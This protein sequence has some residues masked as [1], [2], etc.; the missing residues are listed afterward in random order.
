MYNLC[1]LFSRSHYLAT[2]YFFLLELVEF[3]IPSSSSTF[4]FRPD[5]L[6]SSRIYYTTTM[7]SQAQ[8]TLTMDVCEIQVSPSYD[9][10][11]TSW[12][13]F[14]LNFSGQAELSHTCTLLDADGS[15]LSA[16]S[17]ANKLNTHRQQSL[18]DVCG[19]DSHLF[20][21][22]QNDGGILLETEQ[23]GPSLF[24]SLLK[25]VSAATNSLALFV[26]QSQRVYSF[27]SMGLPQPQ[28]I[29]R[30]GNHKTILETVFPANTS[31]TAVAQLKA[32]SASFRFV[33]ELTTAAWQTTK[34]VQEISILSE[35]D[36]SQILKWNEVSYRAACEP[37]TET[38]LDKIRTMSGMAGQRL[39]L[40]SSTRQITYS[41]LDNLSNQLAGE[42][43]LFS[44][45]LG[46]FL[47]IICHKSGMAIVAMLAA[48]KSGAGFALIDP[49]LPEERLESLLSQLQSEVVLFV[50]E[51]SAHIANVATPQK[52][53]QLLVPPH[54]N[55]NTP[56]G[57]VLLPDCSLSDAAYIIFTSGTTGKPKGVVIEHH[58][59]S[60]SMASLAA[61][62]GL[63]ADTRMLQ[64]ASY[65]FDACIMET[66]STLI[67]GG[68]IF[69]P[70]DSERNNSL[71]EFI[72]QHSLNAMLLTPSVLQMLDPT[73]CPTINT[74]FT[75]GEKMSALATEKWS[76]HVRLINAYGPTETSVLCSLLDGVTKDTPPE[77]LGWAL[78]SS[79]WIVDAEDP[80]RLL[81]IGAVGELVVCGTTLA[82]G[83]LDDPKKT[84]AAFLEN[85]D[86]LPDL[87]SEQVL[88]QR[89]YRTGDL[90]RYG[91]DGSI[92][93]VGR[94]DQQVK[95]RGQRIE[96][97]EIELA[98]RK[99]LPPGRELAVEVAR[100]GGPSC[101]AQL[102]VF[103]VVNIENDFG[104]DVSPR[105][106]TSQT[107]LH[108]FGLLTN[109]L[110]QQLATVLPAY[111]VPSIYVPISALPLTRSAKLDRKLMQTWVE[112]MSVADL[113]KFSS[114]STTKGPAPE[115][116]TE[117]VLQGLWSQILGAS[118]DDISR[119]GHFF[120]LG[121]DS[122]KA[123]KLVSLG[124]SERLSMT[125]EGIF[126]YPVLSELAAHVDFLVG[127]IDHQSSNPLPFSL[128]ET[129]GDLS[130]DATFIEKWKSEAAIQ[131]AVATELVEDIY[132]CT[133]LQE[134]MLALSLKNPDAYTAHFTFETPEV[135]FEKLVRAWQ[136]VTRR[137]SILRTKFISDSSARF[138]QV[139]LEDDPQTVT[140]C[141]TP[142][143][144]AKNDFR[145]ALGE[146]A[147]QIRI[148]LLDGGRAAVTWSS[149]HATY[150]A[151]SVRQIL[152]DVESTY[153][154]ETPSPLRNFSS[155]IRDTRLLNNDTN[156]SQF[157]TSQLQ[158]A[159]TCA[160]PPQPVS[161][162][163]T[164]NATF[165]RRV[166]FSRS[167]SC[168]ITAANL[169][170]AAWA[171][172]LSQYSGLED[173]V[174]GV[175]TSGRTLPI[176]DIDLVRGP[177]IATVPVRTSVKRGTALADF[178][179]QVQKQAV[180]MIPFEQFGLQNIRELSPSARLA[181]DI[182]SLLI[183]QFPE[184]ARPT[185]GQVELL[186][187]TSSKMEDVLTYPLNIECTF[188]Q[189]SI[190][191]N[192]Q[193]DAVLISEVQVQRALAS[194]DAAL[195]SVTQ[196][197][198]SVLLGDLK[199]ISGMDLEQIHLWNSKMPIPTSV[200]I[201]EL[202][203][204][205]AR[206]QP[207][208]AA[209]SAHDGDLTYGQLM[210]HS[211]SLAGKLQKF[212]VGKGSIVPIC[213]EKSVWTQVAILAVLMSGATFVLLDPKLPYARLGSIIED[214]E[215]RIIICQP[216]TSH[217]VSES[218]AE[219]LILDASTFSPVEQGR[220]EN[221]TD[222]L[223]L[224]KSSDVSAEDSA[225]I[226]FTSG[227]TGKPKGIVVDHVALSSTAMA[228][229]K[230]IQIDS[231][232]RVLQFAAYTFDVSIG[233]MLVTL[234]L[235][236]C[237]CVPSESQRLNDLAG[238]MR[239]LKVNHACITSTVAMHLE[240][241][242]VPGLKRLVIGG[243]PMNQVLI[244][245]WATKVD[246]VNIYGP[247]ECT[248][249]CMGKLAL[250]PSDSA[251]NIGY[252]LG[253]VAWITEIDHPEKLAP[254]GAIGELILEGPTLA[255]GYFKDP[256][257][258]AGA[259]LNNPT[260]AV[261]QTKGNSSNSRRV[262]RTGDLV[263]YA[264]DGT[265]TFV[266]RRDRQ[267]KLRGQRIEL[268]EIEHHLRQ[269]LPDQKSE[270]I[271][272][273]I[274]LQGNASGP[275]L[276]AFIT[277][278]AS[279]VWETSGA[280]D[281]NSTAL[282]RF[283]KMLPEMEESMSAA[284]PSYMV[285]TVFIPMENFPLSASGKLDR[286][287]LK[288]WAEDIS[289][290]NISA[291]APK[292]RKYEAPEGQKETSLASLWSS[293]LEVD[294]QIGRHDHFFRMGGDSIRA[295]RL[296][297]AARRQG[298][299]LSVESIFKKP[300]LINMVTQMEVSEYGSEDYEENPVP[301]SLLD[302]DTVRWVKEVVAPGY[303]IQV[304]DIEDAS[305]CT[306]LQEGLVSMSLK[307]QGSY[308]A[309]V[310]YH[311][312][313]SVDLDRLEEVWR[314]MLQNNPILRSVFVSSNSDGVIQIILKNQRS[315]VE[316]CHSHE[317]EARASQ[318]TY[319]LGQQNN[320]ML[321]TAATEDK[322][323][324][325]TWVLHHAAY[326]GWSFYQYLNEV[327]NRYYGN[328][329]AQAKPF[330]CFIRHLQKIDNNAAKNFWAQY[331]HDAQ[332][333][334]FPSTQV[335]ESDSIS[336]TARMKRR[337][338]MPPRPN[339]DITAATVVRA[340]WAIVIAR[341]TGMQDVVFASTM[342]GR[343]TG[344]EGIES[345]RGPTIATVPVRVQLDQEST[346][347][348]V[349]QKVQDGAAEAM[350][351][352]QYG[353]QN[354]QQVNGDAQIACEAR[355][356]LVLQPA[357]MSQ[358][359]QS[360]N[361][362]EGNSQQQDVYTYPLTLECIMGAD[363]TLEVVGTYSD[364]I[365]KEDLVSRLLEYLE[366][367]IRL[368]YSSM[369]N[370]MSW[371]ALLR[372]HAN[373]T[374]TLK[375]WNSGVPPAC[376]S[377][378]H[379]FFEQSVVKTPNKVCISTADKQLTYAG[380]DQLSNF[381]AKHLQDNGVGR[382]SL[383]GMCFGKSWG[384]VVAMLSV[385]KVGGAFFALD[386]TH[387]PERMRE[388]VNRMDSAVVLT[389]FSNLSK[390][391][392][393]HD[394]VICIDNVLPQ[395]VHLCE[396]VAFQ[397]VQVDA[398]DLAFILFT[399]G[400][401][402]KPKGIEITHEA[403]C[404]SI[405]A[406]APRLNLNS[407]S[408]VLQFSAY[409]YDVS[410]A[411]IFTTLSVGATMCIPSAE[412]RLNNLSGF[413]T[414]QK[415][416]WSFQTPTM[417]SFLQPS[418]IPTLKT[419]VLGGEGATEHNLQTWCSKV[420]LIN[421]YGPA[422]CAIWTNCAAGIAEAADRRNVGM[423]VGCSI[424]VTDPQDPQRLLPI[425]AVGELLVGG[426]NIARGYWKDGDKTEAAFLS[427]LSWMPSVGCTGTVYR[428]GDLGRYCSNGTVEVHGRKD[429]QVK[430][431][432]QRIELPEVEA[433]I[434]QCLPPDSDVAVDV[435]RSDSGGPSAQLTAF[436]VLPN[437]T[438]EL[439][440][441]PDTNIISDEFTVQ[442]LNNLVDELDMKLP[443]LLPPYMIPSLYIPILRLPLSPS[444][445]LDRNSLQLWA[446]KIPRDYLSNLMSSG[447]NGG[448]PEDSWEIQLQQLWAEA[449]R[450]PQSDI[451]RG[452]HFFRLGGDSI[453]AMHL[454]SAA[455]RRSLH[456][457]VELMF[458]YP[459]L[460]KMAAQMR[461]QQAADSAASCPEAPSPF[462]LCASSQSI[463]QLKSDVSAQLG[464]DPDALEDVYPCTALQEGMFA[465]SLRQPGSYVA[466]FT[467]SLSD[468]VDPDTLEKA[469]LDVVIRT[470][471]MRTRI[472]TNSE[473]RFMQAVVKDEPVVRRGREEQD[474]LFEILKSG[475]E[476]RQL[477]QINISTSSL[478]WTAH[479]A[480]Y[481][482]MTVQTILND[483]E[484][485]YRGKIAEASIV[486]FNL[487]VQSS[488]MANKEDAQEFWRNS[489]DGAE[490]CE[491]PAL[492]SSDYQPRPAALM[493]RHIVFSR[494]S[495]KEVT[496][497]NLF[498][499]AWA[500]TMSQFAGQD[501]VVF[502]LTISGRSFPLQ[503]VETVRGPTIATV[504]ARMNAQDDLTA[505]KF[506]QTVQDAA[507][508]MI[509]F[510]QLG[511]QNIQRL[512]DN[513][514]S[515]CDIQS[516]LILHV[517]GAEP[518][519]AD[520][521]VKPVMSQIAE[522]SLD[523]FYTNAL[524]IECTINHD[525]ADVIVSY[526]QTVMP[527]TQ[528]QRVLAY[529]EDAIQQLSSGSPMA[530]L[531][532]LKRLHTADQEQIYKWNDQVLE[533]SDLCIHELIQQ[534]AQ[535]Q[536][537][538]P[539][540][541][542]WDGNIAYEEL[543]RLSLRLAEHLQQYYGIRPGDYVPMCFEKCKW[544]QVA[545]L[546]ILR[547]GAAFVPLD[548]KNANSRR[549]AVV[550][551][552]HAKVMLCSDGL[553]R[554]LHSSQVDCLA[555]GDNFMQSL[556]SKSP[557]A[558]ITIPPSSATGAA[559]IV[560]TSGSTGTP[561][562]IV[563]EHAA[564][565]SSALSHGRAI[566]VA[567]GSRV[568]QFAAYTF[569]VSIGDMLV[570]LALGGCVCVPSEAERIND[571]AGAMERMRVNHACITSTVALQLDPGDVPGLQR[572]VVGGEP[573]D[574]SLVERWADRV[575]LINIYGPAEC[576]I[577]CMGKDVSRGDSSHNIGHGMGAIPWVV[578]PRD[579]S[580][581]VP[582]GTA[583]E[584][585]LQ[586]PTLA[587][588]YF[589]DPAKTGAA[590]L[591]SPPWIP[592][593]ASKERERVYRTGDIVRYGEDGSL[594]FLGRKD[595]QVKLRGN[596]IE[597]GEVEVSLRQL[598]PTDTEI[599][600]EIVTPGSA[601]AS[602]TLAAFIGSPS[603]D[604]GSDAATDPGVLESAAAKQNLEQ[605]ITN[606]QPKLSDA[607]PPYMLPSLY[608]PVSRLP[609]SLSAKLDRRTLQ[610]WAENLPASFLRDD[611]SSSTDSRRAPETELEQSLASIW[612]TVLRL[613]ETPGRDDH[614]FRLGG[615][616][617]RAMQLVSQARRQGI[618]LSVDKI[619]QN[620]TLLQMAAS[621]DQDGGALA[622]ATNREQRPLVPFEALGLSSQDQEA[623]K[624]KVVSQCQVPL[625][626]I[627][628]MYPSTPLQEGLIALSIKEPGAYTA[629]LS[630]PL[631]DEMDIE[632][633]KNAWQNV[634]Q[635]VPALRTI[636]FHSNNNG[637]VQVVLREFF[638][639][640]TD[641]PEATNALIMDQ[642]A[643][644][645][646]TRPLS[647][648]TVHESVLT[649]TVHHALYDAYSL[650]LIYN[651]LDWE[652]NQ[653]SSAPA[654]LSG[655]EYGRY[656]ASISNRDT[657]KAKTF[658]ENYLL[659][660]PDAVFPHQHSSSYRPAA[661]KT[662]KTSMRTD[663]S[664]ATTTVANLLRA[665]WALT[666]ATYANI[667]DVVFGT[668]LH[669]R[670]PTSPFANRAVGPTIVTVPV[671]VSLKTDDSLG[672]LL[673]DIHSES[674]SIA[675]NAHIGLQEISKLSAD[676]R[677]A[678]DFQHMFL[679]NDA[680]T[681]GGVSDV[682]G[683]AQVLDNGENFQMYALEV[684][685]QVNAAGVQAKLF[686]DSEVINDTRAQWMLEH[687][688]SVYETICSA[689]AETK[690]S[691]LLHATANEQH[692]LITCNN[693]VPATISK[694][695]HGL[696]SE[697]VQEHPDKEAVVAWDGTFTYSDVENLSN[698][699]AQEL[700]QRGVVAG[701]HIVICFEKSKWAVISMLAVLK[702]GGVCVPLND[703][704][705]LERAQYVVKHV[706]ADICL[707]STGCAKIFDNC[708][709]DVV[710]VNKSLTAN[711]TTAP[712]TLPVVSP[713][714][715]AFV[716]F[717]SGTT[718]YPKGVIQT[719]ANLVTSTLA[720]GS[721]MG[722]TADS[723]VLQF[724]SFTFDVSL[725]DI[726]GAFFFDAC[727]CIPS[728]QQRM[729]S[730][731]GF[732]RDH[733]I[734]QACLTPAVAR[735]LAG[736]GL[737]SLK[738]LSLGGEPLQVT[739]IRHWADKVAL[740]NIYGVT[741]CSIWCAISDPITPQ[742]TSPRNFGHGMGSRLWVVDPANTD[743]LM[744]PGAIG[745]LLVDGPIVS[746][747]Y[748]HDKAKT[749]ASFIANPT[750]H[751]AVQRGETVRL[752]RT[753]DL[754]RLQ[755][756]SSYEYLCRKDTQVKINGQR[757]E[758]G[759][760]ESQ[761]QQVIP[762]HLL[763]VVD[764][765]PVANANLLVAFI[766]SRDALLPTPSQEEEKQ[767]LI[768]KIRSSLIGLLPTHMIPSRY[769]F[770]DTLPLSPSG[771]V[772]RKQLQQQ[773]EAIITASGSE[774]TPAS[775][776]EL[777]GRERQI[778]ELWKTA[779]R[780]ED[781]RL[782]PDSNFFAVGGDSLAAMR[783]VS[784]ARHVGIHLTVQTIFAQPTLAA[785]AARAVIINDDEEPADSYRRFELIPTSNLDS[786]KEKAASVCCQDIID[787][788]PTS[789]LQH[790]Y[791]AAAEDSP[792]WFCTQFVIPL[793]PSTNVTNVVSAWNS[794]SSAHEILRT[795]IIRNG[796]RY[797]QVV[798]RAA[799]PPTLISEDVETYLASNETHPFTAGGEMQ[800]AAILQ[801]ADGQP[802]HL[803][804]SAHHA[805]Y[806]GWSV[807]LILRRL[808]QLY[809]AKHSHPTIHPFGKYIKHISQLNR[810]A[811]QEFWTAQ[812]A[813]TRSQKLRPPQSTD[814][815]PYASAYYEH[816]LPIPSRGNSTITL[817]TILH[818]A[819]GV[820]LARR[821]R[822][823]DATLSLTLT[824][825]NEPVE[826]ISHAI[827]PLITMVPLRVHT[828][829]DQ[830]AT[831]LLRD[832]QTRLRAMVP[833]E[834]TGWGRI[835]GMDA[836]CGRACADAFPMV[837]QAF[838]DDGPGS[839]E[840][841]VFDSECMRAVPM[842]APPLP[843]LSECRVKGGVVTTSLRY[844][845]GM[846]GEEFVREFCAEFERLVGGLAGAGGEERIGE[847]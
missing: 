139:V 476:G 421:S 87:G 771:K 587:R 433:R 207:S 739:D 727:V 406:H 143:L 242:A 110:P 807:R 30:I 492:P 517:A 364:A 431:R 31:A 780:Q 44:E 393:F 755:D 59:I 615:D 528:L 776:V 211:I 157:W 339:S 213:F 449:L 308:V 672:N 802:T 675:A 119:H 204:N 793:A 805:I 447:Q 312:P 756:E 577:W 227:S 558:G 254:I 612:H 691:S 477:S 584:L 825:R 632:R 381:F 130:S 550:Q 507:T 586:G 647:V 160:F 135:D 597:L 747:G 452:D 307:K 609:L 26:T 349:L 326:D 362:F 734:D 69:I 772:N 442:R 493:E 836:D 791:M 678:S 193:F 159:E 281:A 831:S 783:L 357:E 501:D 162:S 126:T 565:S 29:C 593:L 613:E 320:I 451:K 50:D 781:L 830:T 223:S 578:N 748:L 454:V 761:I 220:D 652:Y 373:D 496:S 219:L 778:A 811:A 762:Q 403:F 151:I 511:L 341:Y 187:S 409:T 438:E 221:W 268:A 687:F 535:L 689:P 173:V 313:P 624:Q 569:D 754:V 231:N 330:T 618:F 718:G 261:S 378:V 74:V 369:N 529:F 293:I 356:L 610:S 346:I 305:P 13:I 549:D 385:L 582:I 145:V 838:Q 275:Q 832:V 824:G 481:D 246:L 809:A 271:V 21:N 262:Y 70:S 368:L 842:G 698:V 846:F 653:P 818:A 260:W 132:P 273:V 711:N 296:S 743:C 348:A 773:G 318:F 729:D 72:Q 199:Q 416:T 737:P 532:D 819:M 844:D 775:K 230:A 102:V 218:A 155:F 107:D 576:T 639:W 45:N 813:G 508:S 602:A 154:Q 509:P 138:L 794:L 668:T 638:S 457:T 660:T 56:P 498:R 523:G 526:D 166:P 14:C 62:S 338:D 280:V 150:D 396:P 524:N 751:P 389:S 18:H 765:L 152:Q 226:V 24:G 122:I 704:Y 100:P 423:P 286:K 111:M 441:L 71:P 79:L 463:E 229:G 620:P 169:V 58:S 506:L 828:S 700:V 649:W 55:P 38:L 272:E 741:E 562:G 510:E 458:K 88:P 722:Y 693:S 645:T 103:I 663:I 628:D 217:A 544:T 841:S 744:P 76:P 798:H 53:R 564:V 324:T 306:A 66:F 269:N 92:H 826:G 240:P 435:I 559:Y 608:I 502:G 629:R 96:L 176:K 659:K 290:S 591:Q 208:A 468:G 594:Y 68:S 707:S 265:I 419:L 484:A 758:L 685:C 534:Q 667:D 99:F 417:A 186:R 345:V 464:V 600:V 740:R 51:N 335:A 482:G 690:I 759:D 589:N 397:S 833:W 83:Y 787:I 525:S 518:Q 489:L 54:Q 713:D 127:E 195:Q 344:I 304:D 194:F 123:M 554:T 527:D 575:D 491:F 428:T 552:L 513:A 546:A 327:N 175:T 834:H 444:A 43:L 803:V 799:S 847:L 617:I 75:G 800:R 453:K 763:T 505:G 90:A 681:E 434:R 404:S 282:E 196:R 530:K 376:R 716:M 410:M 188:Q 426:P 673:Q 738:A 699:L 633:L 300:L 625:E 728:E 725:G 337:F 607:L 745:E 604:S 495:C 255:R 190:S 165:S 121:G 61:A 355:S 522:K 222:S 113:G 147:N 270:A 42:I 185:Q 644:Q 494:S 198:D 719:H 141:K 15:Q 804:W 259:F 827:A 329:I 545:I 581:L 134:G 768:T 167:S 294:G 343:N 531:G 237:V 822:T 235:G 470:P 430:L 67:M 358:N 664:S 634:V 118:L 643:N 4:S 247:A 445:K 601:T 752:Y 840:E 9:Q 394:C 440:L 499:A 585:V 655:C 323:T 367:T 630:F 553:E 770:L 735:T 835:A 334:D 174:F 234:A 142:D 845:P 371:D 810:A 490:K 657:N 796:T 390:A 561:K 52:T 590:F 16:T 790:D 521:N 736:K 485:S 572:L 580:R 347:A 548:P 225:Y 650:N 520:E 710:F 574:E 415:A 651:L 471:I 11:A 788:L 480:V 375:E 233:D 251:S 377:T 598:L 215:A 39:A 829:A 626:N 670:D 398:S 276:V 315:L 418:A 41:E 210:S 717:T 750:W 128:L 474:S 465:L 732:I 475:S 766:A 287:A 662:I 295:M 252:G 156:T 322:P 661:R 627:Q 503:G 764:Q 309:R 178:L 264:P 181:C 297:A 95:L 467:F 112:N 161:H 244:D 257:R 84:A 20:E 98:L 104:F 504:P 340:A 205:Q 676:C 478:V 786:L 688:G 200:P 466:R 6:P 733:G 34:S 583:G 413:I 209:V 422:E 37:A 541:C 450:V 646:S 702:A 461:E 623:L 456:L 648:F 115:N 133:P 301:F 705:P 579:P 560:F 500:M 837:V 479:H 63:N 674:A 232:A 284:L 298:L 557:S 7:G 77:K 82:R 821:A 22:I 291:L 724:A 206:T 266:G 817:P 436:I 203:M 437:V 459:I 684:E 106:V 815:Q 760:I 28:F 619:F 774:E 621:V 388:I 224:L 267:I 392:Q 420:Q 36:K 777:S 365:C 769:I 250:T 372:P 540:I 314:Q 570:T 93:I 108:E 236:G 407:D 86:W 258:T 757:V 149:H 137:T 158:D 669:G 808:S 542:A 443:E 642:F 248:V 5:P 212:S 78:G 677:R 533:Y 350:A 622:E 603:L 383:V 469:W 515:A 665:A 683:A 140:I 277:G 366:E 635:R 8:N 708:A 742:S 201:Y 551:D 191:I 131:C 57:D 686:Y 116:T 172:V 697:K 32:F 332:L 40:C 73:E 241:Q 424:F 715:A 658:W 146:R 573:M 709:V 285:P 12:A 611:A 33:I 679:V 310:T 637:L 101:T 168:D 497:S 319:A 249:W 342:S 1:R 792:G 592:S 473:G 448:P 163:V 179:S 714:D 164:A 2:Q 563:V 816:K 202:V 538:A 784:C 400:S 85:L 302:P 183:L 806:D 616:S 97:A 568:L 177:T 197:N 636:L 843:M 184:D 289:A 351:Y 325:L 749:E 336:A 354:I 599:A 253:A 399:S 170:R 721:R 536:P 519:N 80:N 243:E 49:K 695:L 656:I 239:D 311:L 556:I 595:R 483:V 412:D 353:L 462:A 331:L 785:M 171:L 680:S 606:I 238:A 547:A 10:L 380:V 180:A 303:K 488:T 641:S 288:A 263:R 472:I 35:K 148:S 671:R 555:I 446:K 17:K 89:V 395:E 408:R 839:G 516:V 820:L 136:H 723:R 144:S 514:Q 460:Y 214:V 425:G 640:S 614:F 487:F 274:T 352:E 361:M 566:K 363:N 189:G 789:P 537:N 455:S 379:N 427:N 292:K 782:A 797:L 571:L 706:G 64:Y 429:R 512:S 19:P 414:D 703:T 109:D 124:R 65:T 812:L 129:P 801:N 48:W 696:F 192:A 753:G 81:P 23:L 439:S 682:L 391:Q 120:R 359:D 328:D 3:E 692:S 384:A 767:G 278:D 283:H 588:C 105:I 387:P 386:P 182:R 746:K 317:A 60:K 726:F 712:P 94:K 486:P 370:P 666:A 27:E 631:P 411:E 539:A 543:M 360:Q 567:S 316:R 405:L 25:E 731:D 333:C 256:I 216:H 47:P 402:G 720:I 605:L 245:R 814:K 694:T 228:H 779:T 46:P 374:A 117:I 153:Y 114:A 125:V 730:L 321:L 432:G 596:R 823:P 91:D 382:G 795:R 299:V 654:P 701:S 401:T 279:G